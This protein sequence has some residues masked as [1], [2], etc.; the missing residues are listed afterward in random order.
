MYTSYI[1]ENVASA[2]AIACS[3]VAKVH[4]WDREGWWFKPRC[5]HN[6]ISAAVEPLSKALNPTL[7]QGGLS[8]A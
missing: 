1:A 6:K 7:L 2:A 3:L 4:D 5:S 8:P